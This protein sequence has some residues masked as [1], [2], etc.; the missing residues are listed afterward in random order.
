MSVKTEEA[1]QLI[2]AEHLKLLAIF[3]YITAGVTALFACIPFIHLFM[4]IMFIFAGAVAGAKGDGAPPMIIGWF[5]VVI[6]GL[7]ILLGW[8][9]A[10]L[11]FL[12]GRYL[13]T[14][15]HYTFCFVIAALSCLSFPYGTVLGV[16]TIIVLARPSVKRL[17]TPHPPSPPPPT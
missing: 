14:R 9:L 17:F 2:D 10:V 16:F 8:T 13:A 11:K 1:Q 3:Y 15:K 12:A 4:G 6:A 7:I 5:F